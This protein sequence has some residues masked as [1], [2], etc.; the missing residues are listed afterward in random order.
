MG[1]GSH[2][3]MQRITLKAPIEGVPT[4]ADFALVESPIPPLAEGEALF[5]TRLVSVDLG[6]AALLAAE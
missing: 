3:M 1:T 6:E 5:A 2:P 4:P